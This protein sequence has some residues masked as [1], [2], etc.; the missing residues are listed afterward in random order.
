MSQN[1]D[2]HEPQH[3]DVQESD[4]NADSP[5]GLAGGMGVSSEWEGPARGVE[6]EVTYGA[7]PYPEP[8]MEPASGLTTDNVSPAE[9]AEAGT[10]EIN[11]PSPGAQE[12]DP[13]DNPGHGI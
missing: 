11:P 2:P 12:A 8:E 5:E 6:G 3:T 10:P 7:A 9:S 1:P 4:P 13:E